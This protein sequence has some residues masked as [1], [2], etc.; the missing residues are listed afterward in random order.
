MNSKPVSKAIRLL[1][2]VRT[3]ISL[4]K[5]TGGLGSWDVADTPENKKL[6]DAIET[7]SSLITR[8]SSDV[9]PDSAASFD[10]RKPFDTIELSPRTR[11]RQWLA[12]Q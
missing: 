11:Y 7:L 3:N 12:P 1:Q 9:P 5:S 4:M 10:P 8:M 2:N 6:Q